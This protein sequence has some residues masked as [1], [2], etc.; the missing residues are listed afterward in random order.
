MKT[1]SAAVVTALLGVLSVN[2]AHA[3]DDAAQE[4]ARRAILH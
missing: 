1:S 4:G 3:E 2:G